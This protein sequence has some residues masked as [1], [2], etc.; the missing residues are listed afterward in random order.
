MEINANVPLDERGQNANIKFKV[1]D[2]G[3]M[4][5]CGFRH[6]YGK[7]VYCLGIT[8]D[9]SLNI[10]ISDN[11]VGTIDILDDQWLQPYDF[12]GMIMSK[13]INPT[14]RLVQKRVYSVMAN[15]ME[16]GIIG[17]WNEGDYI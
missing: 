16:K 14:V 12:Q 3:S 4:E 8:N 10:Q 5:E 2:I 7:W 9:I 11:E 15:L 1:L 6:T 17:G 13:K